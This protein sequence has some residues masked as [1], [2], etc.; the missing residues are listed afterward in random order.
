MRDEGAV[1]AENGADDS[2]RSAVIGEKGD[3]PDAAGDGPSDGVPDNISISDPRH[4]AAAYC[5]EGGNFCL[6]LCN[7]HPDTR[8][9]VGHITNTAYGQCGEKVDKYCAWHGGTI[10]PCW[11]W[12]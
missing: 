4:S 12:E 10:G 1:V 8:V 11:G 5:S 9:V 6:A 7:D 3:A 2:D